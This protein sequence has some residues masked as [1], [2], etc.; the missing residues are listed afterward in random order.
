[1]LM[2]SISAV[3]AIGLL[4]GCADTMSGMTTSSVDTTA[5]APKADPACVSLASQIDA[6][7]R[8]GATERVEKAAA[9]KGKATTVSVNKASLTKMAELDRANA[10]FQSK[11]STLPP[12]YRS[13]AVAPAGGP[14]SGAPAKSA[15]VA[16]PLAQPAQ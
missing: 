1:M 4:T 14:V 12:Q 10:E 11:C 15:S 9:T 2:R 5:A 16:K 6:L 7:R 8:D 3:F 13:A